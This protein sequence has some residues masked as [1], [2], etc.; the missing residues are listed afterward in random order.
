VKKSKEQVKTL[1]ENITKSKDKIEKYIE[2]IK[3]VLSSYND[4]KNKAIDA[5]EQIDKKFSEL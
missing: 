3:N 4:M 5:L 1:E 2:S